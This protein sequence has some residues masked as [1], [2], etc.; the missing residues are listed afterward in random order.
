MR[1]EIQ[2]IASLIEDYRQD[3]KIIL[4]EKRIEDWVNQFRADD[5]FFL[6]TELINIFEKRYF[7]KR[8]VLESMAAFINRVYIDFGYQNVSDFLSDAIFLS[9][10]PENKSQ[11]VLLKLLDDYLKNEFDFGLDKCGNKNK[12]HFIYL[13]DILCTGNTL[14]S[15]LISWLNSLEN[16]ESKLN[17]LL[18]GDIN[19]IVCYLFLHNKNYQ[20]TINRLQLNLNTQQL[21][22]HIKFYRRIKIE[23]SNED[24]SALDFIFPVRS[25]R[26]QVLQYE[27]KIIEEVE[28]YCKENKYSTS[29]N[30][31]YRDAAKPTAEKLFTN[32]ENRIR[33]ENI[34]LEK[35][36]EIIS[37]ESVNIKNMRALGYDLPSHKNFGFGTLAFTYRNVPNN[38][39]LVFWYAGGGFTPLFIKNA[40]SQ[41]N[42]YSAVFDI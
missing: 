37:K 31:F 1:E 12:K 14:Y 30:E 10:Q 38:T 16:K 20:K 35:G 23:N 18:S 7:S 11:S 28:S 22:E 9:L 5:R 36:I 4:N 19:L 13:D 27:R 21:S 8:K 29:T 42:S 2:K 39:P 41:I 6:L 15:N 24:S 3:E 25:D 32:K 34:I 40:T 33:F 17:R 26:T